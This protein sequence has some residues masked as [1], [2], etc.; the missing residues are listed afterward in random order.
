MRKAMD[1]AESDGEKEERGDSLAPNQCRSTALTV[2]PIK[3]AALIPVEG[4]PAFRKNRLGYRV[5]RGAFKILAM[6]SHRILVNGND[7]AQD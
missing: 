4:Q 2:A 3:G 7:Q 5:G 1:A 6:V